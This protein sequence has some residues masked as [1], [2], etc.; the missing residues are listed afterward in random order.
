M[1]SDDGRRDTIQ[2]RPGDRERGG[3][4]QR[5][6]GR[7]RSLSRR[8]CSGATS[9][10]DRRVSTYTVTLKTSGGEADIVILDANVKYPGRLCI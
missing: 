4:D 7:I 10:S 2:T 3:A 1:I 9:D 8:L 5:Y 6:S